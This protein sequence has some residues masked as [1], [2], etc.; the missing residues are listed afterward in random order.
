MSLPEIGSRWYWAGKHW[1]VTGHDKRD[2]EP[3]VRLKSLHSKRKLRFPVIWRLMERK[4]V[5]SGA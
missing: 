2:G 4:A 5:P 1:E 3:A